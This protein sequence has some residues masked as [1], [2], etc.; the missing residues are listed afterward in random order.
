MPDLLLAIDPN[1]FRVG[2]GVALRS[3]RDLLGL[4]QDTLAAKLDVNGAR[5]WEWETGATLIRMDR[6]LELCAALDIS[7]VT[8]IANAMT[9]AEDA[10]RG[11]HS[12]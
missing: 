4:T 2:L 8:V 5:I 1:D 3:R 7:I 9:Y 12:R 10:A 11:R 6:L